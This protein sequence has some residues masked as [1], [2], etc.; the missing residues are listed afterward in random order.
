[1]N[2]FGRYINIS[3]QVCDAPISFWQAL[4]THSLCKDDKKAMDEAQE[5]EDSHQDEFW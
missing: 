5:W 1:M 2:F 3:C 4:K